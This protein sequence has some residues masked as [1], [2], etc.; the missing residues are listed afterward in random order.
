MAMSS[1]I[2]DDERRL[3]ALL[4]VTVDE[5]N[6]DLFLEVKPSPP[7]AE[8]IVHLPYRTAADGAWATRGFDLINSFFKGIEIETA[9]AIAIAI[10]MIVVVILRIE[11]GTVQCQ[12]TWQYSQQ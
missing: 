8:G 4:N 3:A 6:D 10:V 11:V 5:L 12:E 7:R 1:V 9:V 2:N